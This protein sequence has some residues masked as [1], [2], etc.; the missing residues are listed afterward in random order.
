MFLTLRR[1]AAD[2]FL[3]L[4]DAAGLLLSG[5]G[6]AV[7]AFFGKVLLA[8]VLGALALG[9][10]LRLAGRRRL[11]PVAPAPMPGWGRVAA[12]ILSAVEVAVLV[13]ATDLPVRFHQP[14]FQLYHWLLVL[15]VL[16]MAYRLQLWGWRAA[17]VARRAGL[18]P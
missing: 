4:A 10:L 14:G 13:E 18:R 7:V 15:A 11:P 12:A 3:L 1:K 16:L 8:V 6:A 9:F 2:T 17:V 5:S